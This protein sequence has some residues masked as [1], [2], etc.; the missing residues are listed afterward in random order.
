MTH[1][2]EEQ[3]VQAYYGEIDDAFHHHLEECP[4]CAATF[5]RLKEMLDSVSDYP[6]PERNSAYGAEVWARLVPHLPLAQPRP[7]W[8]RWWVL[9]PVLATLLTVAFLA[10]RFTEQRQTG[11]ST[12]ARE[13][14]LLMAISDHLERS[15][16]VLTEL[17]HADPQ[18]ADLASERDR[19]RDLV[20][21]NRLLR[22]TAVH[23][24]DPSVVALL[25]QLERVLVDVANSPSAL[26][27]DDLAALQQR[28]ES[29]GLLFKVRVTGANTREK[30]QKL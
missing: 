17:V 14:V 30:G 9:G 7:G 24:D 4:E 27:P 23:M 8:L 13:R 25:D 29:E 16:I 22:E 21:E 28:I 10:G 5:D 18:A 15:Q 1:P 20:S 2:D 11:I 6:V 19:A 26:P 12:T 3:L